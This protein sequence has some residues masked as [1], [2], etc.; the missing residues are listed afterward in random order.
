MN[1]EKIVG[2]IVEPGFVA[3][4]LLVT[5][6]FA[7]KAYRKR[8]EKGILLLAIAVVCQLGFFTMHALFFRQTAWEFRSESGKIF[9]LWQLASPVIASLGWMLLSRNEEPNQSPEATPDGVA[10][11]SR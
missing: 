9:E 8:H 7:I 2:L 6:Y 11:R 3:L 4:V 10:D 1:I 5:L